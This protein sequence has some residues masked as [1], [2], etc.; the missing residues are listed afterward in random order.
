MEI[1]KNLPP[2]VFKYKNWQ[3][4]TSVRHVIPIKIWYGETQWHPKKQW[5]L[6]AW[7]MDKGA[8]RSFAIADIIEFFPK[9]N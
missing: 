7:D 2:L 6:T 1:D 4:E 5:L 8:E 9:E 3:G